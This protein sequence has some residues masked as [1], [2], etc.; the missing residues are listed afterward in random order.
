MLDV[1]NTNEEQNNQLIPQNQDA[2]F[3]DENNVPDSMM[4]AKVKLVQKEQMDLEL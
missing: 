2:P 4:E 3:M 1:Y